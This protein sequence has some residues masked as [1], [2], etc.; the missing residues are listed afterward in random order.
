M[1]EAEEEAA[2]WRGGTGKAAHSDAL[3]LVR[4]HVPDA[5]QGVS[6]QGKLSVLDKS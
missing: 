2:S 6:V 4:Q 1:G 3:G 5:A